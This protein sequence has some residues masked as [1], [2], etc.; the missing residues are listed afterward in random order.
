MLEQLTL[1]LK[2]FNLS[3]LNPAIREELHVAK[4]HLVNNEEMCFRVS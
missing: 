4:L 1:H 3:I 2:P